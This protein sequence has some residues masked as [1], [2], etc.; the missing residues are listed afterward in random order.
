MNIQKTLAMA[1]L[2]GLM[3]G[4][5]VACSG[6]AKPDAAPAAE[7]PAAEAPAAKAEAPAAMADAEQPATIPEH[8]CRGLNEC[9][10]Q[11]GCHVEGGNS[12]TGGNECKGK[13]GCCTMKDRSEC[14]PHE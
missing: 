2:S 5:L 3:A 6:D 13:G 14:P 7:A 8:A 4:S 9:K 10:G 12:C 11:G 1:A